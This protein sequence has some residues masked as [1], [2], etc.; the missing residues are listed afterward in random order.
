MVSTTGGEIHDPNENHHYYRQ[1]SAPVSIAAGGSDPLQVGDV[2]SDTTANLIK[3]CTGVNPDI[4]TSTEGSGTFS[5]PGSATDNALVRFDGTSGDTGQDSGVLLDDSDNMSGVN[6]LT[7]KG[8]SVLTIDGSGDVT[9]TNFYHSIAGAGGSPDH[10]DG[11]AAGSDGQL[12]FIRPSDDTV[13]ITVRNNQNAAATNNILLAGGDQDGQNYAMDDFFDQLLLIYDAGIDTNGAW[14]EI[15]R[16]VPWV[17]TV[18]LAC[19]NEH[20]T[21]TEINSGSSSNVIT[22]V[23]FKD[24][25]PGKRYF[26]VKMIANGTTL[27]TGDDLNG[28]RFTLPPDLAGYNLT[29][30]QVHVFTVSSSGLPTFQLQNV[31]QTADILTTEV[32]IDENEKDSNTAATPHLINTGEDDYTAGDELQLD[33][34][35]AGT[36]TKGCQLTLTFQR[37]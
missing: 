11:I 9:P 15:S 29:D 10:L 16:A 27:T 13:R 4:F 31:T 34:D 7:F 28:G 21:F 30:I 22:P 18:T 35:I 3:R 6:S 2:W 17:G 5:G 14:L 1:D 26:I 33:C 12:L 36:G 8:D 37:P 32:T 24:S 25:I 23:R 19:I 20:A